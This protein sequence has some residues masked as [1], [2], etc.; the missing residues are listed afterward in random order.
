[1]PSAASLTVGT[2]TF[3]TTCCVC[4]DCSVDLTAGGQQIA[5][6]S[7]SD[8]L[9]FPCNKRRRGEICASCDKPLS[10]E[11]VS[12]LGTCF[13]KECFRCSTCSTQLGQNIPCV[14]GEGGTPLCAPCDKRARGEVCSV[15]N[16]LLSREFVTAVGKKF[17]KACFRCS[18]CN[19][20]LGASQPCLQ[21]T[22]GKKIFCEPCYAANNPQEEVEEEEEAATPT[23]KTKMEEKEKS[24]PPPPQAAAVAAGRNGLKHI[25]RGSQRPV[26]PA[27]TQPPNS[28]LP[29]PPPSSS[30]SASDRGGRGGGHS[31]GEPSIPPRP[32]GV[33]AK[34][35]RPLG[36]NV[37]FSS[38]PPP[39]SQSPPPDAVIPESDL[40]PRGK[41]KTKSKK[42]KK[43]T[44]TKK[45]ATVVTDKEAGEEE[46][47]AGKTQDQGQP[48]RVQFGESP[49]SSSSVAQ[50]KTTK[51][52]KSGRVSFSDAV[53][54]PTPSPAV[55]S[56]ALGGK[57]K[58]AMKKKKKKK[59]KTKT[60]AEPKTAKNK[61]SPTRTKGVSFGTSP[62]TAIDTKKQMKLE[63]P[64]SLQLPVDEEDDDDLHESEEDD[65][66]ESNMA[67]SPHINS[68]SAIP[69][70][71]PSLQKL[72][73]S[74][75]ERAMSASLAAA[76]SAGEVIPP[77]SPSRRKMRKSGRTGTMA[78]AARQV[79]RHSALE[80]VGNIRE[81]LASD[82][83]CVN[84]NGTMSAA[85]KTAFKQRELEQILSHMS[86]LPVLRDIEADRT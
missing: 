55:V 76:H 10:G 2:R 69:Q 58:T 75:R 16:D 84:A 60:E 79:R 28:P 37:S 39:P 81:Q 19:V 52:K 6:G 64:P 49:P 45:K 34:E 80:V 68:S 46:A 70:R 1:M 43:K 78:V 14:K 12:A 67:A 73:L 57:K 26:A 11:F 44:T 24:P 5:V 86:V 53:S 50:L 22:L 56:P 82:G 51:K 47:T 25:Q 29:P 42:K 85:P 83:D 17:H 63:P 27:D 36:K 31:G 8:L 61:K 40:S 48:K 33:A 3:H 62:A 23:M 13:H 66:F 35:K 65:A 7:N 32:P 30:A 59:K 18:S 15:C 38:T 71:S 21:G 54:S 20:E 41:V 74:P 77:R 9:C 4:T 72:I